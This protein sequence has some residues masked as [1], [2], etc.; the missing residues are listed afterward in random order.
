[1]LHYAR[2]DTHFLLDIYDHL[3][4][5]LSTYVPPPPPTPVSGDDVDSDELLITPVEPPT[6]PMDVDAP[7]EPT[8]LSTV[9]T[10]SI[11][12]SA[13]VFEMLP[14]NHR[15]GFSDGGWR[16]LLV[17]WRHA[18]EHDVAV[19]VPTLPIKS[20]WGPGELHLEVLKALHAWREGVA[21]SED[22]IGRASCRERVS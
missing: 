13:G 18:K 16:S 5:A 17:K 4:L 2:S 10:R 15:T 22:E 11:G 7:A 12:T 8:H 6:A 9:F 19:A 3:R 1:M 14:Y 20:G 21:R